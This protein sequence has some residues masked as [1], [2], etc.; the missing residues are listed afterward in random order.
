MI[1]RRGDKEA[2]TGNSRMTA[3]DWRACF[4]TVASAKFRHNRS[5][6]ARLDE[7][8]LFATVVKITL[9]LHTVS[10]R[11]SWANTRFAA[12][13]WC[14]STG[15]QAICV[16]S[17][18]Y[19]VIPICAATVVVPSEPLPARRKRLPAAARGGRSGPDDTELALD[20]NTAPDAN[21]ICVGICTRLDVAVAY[22]RRKRPQLYCS[23]LLHKRVTDR[24]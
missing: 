14:C 18:S 7:D 2:R 15:A 20:L 19:L 3:S 23:A 21:P 6:K 9:P 11:P 13:R 12:T 4:A 24:L 17:S 8:H 22:C 5:S 10:S 1:S 16:Q